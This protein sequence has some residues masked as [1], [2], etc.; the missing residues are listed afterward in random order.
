M[1]ADTRMDFVSEG[2]TT[3]GMVG[4]V[5]GA[6][7]GFG[8]SNGHTYRVAASATT[9]IGLN[10]LEFGA[11]Y[12]TSVGR[13]WGIDE[14]YVAR[15]F[16]D[17]NPENIAS[18][19][20]DLNTSGYT[21]F[22]DLP[23]HILARAMGGVGYNLLGTEQHNSQNFAGYLDTSKDKP[24]SHYYQAPYKPIYYGAFVQNKI[25]FRDIVLNMGLRVDV[26]DRNL[27][28]LRDK[29]AYRP[30]ERAGDLGVG[31]P[32]GIGSEYAVYFSGVMS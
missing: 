5:G 11:E 2:E 9:Q 32:S 20:P 21:N 17:G 30:I 6:R 22:S 28:V 4:P 19:D 26:W 15:I 18:D 29:Y 31:L 13:S 27:P 10:Q 12:E 16:A 23:T 8:K 24:E 1:F 14:E 3:A 7:L 25:E